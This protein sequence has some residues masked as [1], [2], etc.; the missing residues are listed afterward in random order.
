MSAAAVGAV[1][2]FRAELTALIQLYI[3]GVF[4][5]FTL[6]QIG[7]VRH[8]T[9]LLRT[10]T[11]V[12]ARRK[13]VR[14]RVVNSVGLVSTGAVLLIVLVTKFLA[15]AWI[16]I[17]AMGSVFILM[18]MI[19]RH[20]DTVN[21]ELEEQ[22]AAHD[23]EVV[24]PSRNHALVLVSKLHLPTLRALAYA[25]A[26][27][28]DVLEAITVSVDDVET[29]ELVRQWEDSDVSVPLKVIASPYREITRPVLDYVKRVSKESPRTVVTV[30]IPEYVVGRWWEQLLH[31]QS[32]FRLKTRLLFMPG[33]MVTSV[34]WQ[35]TSSERIN[36]LEPHAAPGDMRRG[37]FD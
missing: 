23:N 11:D 9:R 18:K 33:V 20:Y 3:V 36:T 17:V 31:N 8:W 2:A 28:P 13:M 24:L 34:P 32:A 26:T 25:R 16:A 6:S 5:S 37:I 14:S 15:G 7:M 4:I 29:R 35:L 1:V 12:A 22:A 19:R 21:R 27:R 10:E 30:F